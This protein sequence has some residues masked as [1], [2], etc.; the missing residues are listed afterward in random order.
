MPTRKVSYVILQGFSLMLNALVNRLQFCLNRLFEYID[1]AHE[2]VSRNRFAKAEI[3]R[4]NHHLF[5]AARS[6]AVL[7]GPSLNGACADLSTAKGMALEN[8]TRT[9]R[10]QYNIWRNSAVSQLKMM[11]R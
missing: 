6:C 11:D 5:P 9:G 2:R 7:N 3:S 10:E 1:I 8:M 4:C